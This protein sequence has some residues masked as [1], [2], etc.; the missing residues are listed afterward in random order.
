VAVVFFAAFVPLR[1]LPEK[2]KVGNVA[3]LGTVVATQ[4]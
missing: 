1:T 4:L 3:P 2:V